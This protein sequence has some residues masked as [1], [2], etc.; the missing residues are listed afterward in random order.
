MSPSIPWGQE[1][2][3]SRTMALRRGPVL[4]QKPTPSMESKESAGRWRVNKHGDFLARPAWAAGRREPETRSQGRM[5]CPGGG[6]AKA[7]RGGQGG[8]SPL[9]GRG[10]VSSLRCPGPGGSGQVTTL[11][12]LLETAGR[13]G[14]L[15]C[16]LVAPSSQ[17][18]VH[19][20]AFCEGLCLKVPSKWN[21]PRPLGKGT[22]QPSS[23][24]VVLRAPGW[25][26]GSLRA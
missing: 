9:P 16:L 15:P 26:A 7:S 25:L 22:I 24:G 5:L 14:G 13:G 17:A 18:G 10:T 20:L 6:P 21:A 11:G 19:L 12:E 4:V 1:V 3:W 8:P 23:Q 2:P